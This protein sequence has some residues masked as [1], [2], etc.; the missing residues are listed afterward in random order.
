[1]LVSELTLSFVA[2]KLMKQTA[3]RKS[4]NRWANESG[5]HEQ[6]VRTVRT[7]LAQSSGL[8]SKKTSG[9]GRSIFLDI[10]LYRT[11]QMG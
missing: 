10:P 2:K 9:Q 11:Y 6:L 1:M 8:E 5:N 4:P 3:Y 7:D